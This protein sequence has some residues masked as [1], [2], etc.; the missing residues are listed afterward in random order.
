MN[1]F[2]VVLPSNSSMAHFSENRTTHFVTQFPKEIRLFG[3]WSV[4]LAE[5]QIPMNFQHISNEDA[6]CCVTVVT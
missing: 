6:E 4:T 3:T 1:E 2:Y 5:I